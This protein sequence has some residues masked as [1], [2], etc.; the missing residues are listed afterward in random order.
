M[1]AVRSVCPLHIFFSPA[2]KDLTPTNGVHEATCPGPLKAAAMSALIGL[3]NLLDAAKEEVSMAQSDEEA[4]AACDEFRSNVNDAIGDVTELLTARNAE[5]KET[6]ADSDKEIAA[7]CSKAKSKLTVSEPGD[8][9]YVTCEIKI[10]DL[11][12]E[13]GNVFETA[14]KEP[15]TLF[16]KLNGV[17]SQLGTTNCRNTLHLF[18]NLETHMYGISIGDKA[19]HNWANFRVTKDIIFQKKDYNMIC[20]AAPVTDETSD[21]PLDEITF[22]SFLVKMRANVHVDELLALL[23]DIGVKVENS[24]PAAPLSVLGHSKGNTPQ[25]HAEGADD[26]QNSVALLNMPASL[27]KWTVGKYKSRDFKKGDVVIYQSMTLN[28]RLVY[29]DKGA[30]MHESLI[31]DLM[32]V[33]KV[34]KSVLFQTSSGDRYTIKLS[35]ENAVRLVTVISE[36][37]HNQDLSPN[38]DSVTVGSPDTNDVSTP[39]A[40]ESDDCSFGSLSVGEEGEEEVLFQVKARPVLV[41]QTPRRNYLFEFHVNDLDG[42]LYAQQLNE[43]LLQLRCKPNGEQRM[44]WFS[45]DDLKLD[46][47]FIWT[48]VRGTD[49]SIEDYNVPDANG[50][51]WKLR[52]L[53][54]LLKEELTGE[55]Y[56]L[57]VRDGSRRKKLVDLFEELKKMCQV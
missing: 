5:M 49:V 44:V 39:T 37:L 29:Q 46:P 10:G 28:H 23:V 40:A 4:A 35:E 2:M 30:I 51:M 19:G 9:L 6:S 11:V 54:I 48:I 8:A 41:T 18:Q 26:V 14:W 42:S 27:S 22:E 50:F 20:F 52:L 25:A 53:R 55:V 1:I 7:M 15:I 57:R 33:K 36:I 56:M 38:A 47:D 12:D 45:G 32:A 43:G 17:W 16:K 13:A 34:G 24:T 31:K 3:G 21:G